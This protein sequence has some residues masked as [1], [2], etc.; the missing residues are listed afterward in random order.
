MHL[1]A[2]L[3]QMIQFTARQTK[4]DEDVVKSGDVYAED[5]LVIVNKFID[6][7]NYAKNKIIRERYRPTKTETV[8]IGPSNSIDLNTLS[9]I[10]LKVKDIYHSDT[11]AKVTDWDQGDDFTL[12]FPMGTS[13]TS[14]DIE[15]AYM[16]PDFPNNPSK[17]DLE[18][19]LDLPEAIVDYRVLCYYSAYEYHAIK[20]SDRDLDKAS[21]FLPK[22][23]DGF[24]HIPKSVKGVRKVKDRAGY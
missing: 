17:T 22:W 12:R 10:V 2:T 5:A 18:M 11:S 7:F 15:Y 19:V 9:K 16:I 14:V 3:D 4:R 20:G 6:G 23:N 13:G 24:L 8:T 1:N 21:L